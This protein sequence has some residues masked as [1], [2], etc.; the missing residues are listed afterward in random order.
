MHQKFLENHSCMINSCLFV[1]VVVVVIICVTEWLPQWNTNK[2]WMVIDSVIMNCYYHPLSF[3][4]LCFGMGNNFFEVIFLQAYEPK[5]SFLLL[6][7]RLFFH[8]FFHRDKFFFKNFFKNT[9]PK[10]QKFITIHFSESC[11]HLQEQNFLWHG[12]DCWAFMLHVV[13]FLLLIIFVMKVLDQWSCNN[14]HKLLL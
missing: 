10:M 8:F 14:F 4:A 5:T 7:S 12:K 13:S 2:K 9:D 1:L 3:S 11:Y 6:F